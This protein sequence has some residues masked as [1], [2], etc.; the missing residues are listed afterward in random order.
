MGK[1]VIR[2]SGQVLVSNLIVADSVFTRM[3]GLLGKDSLPHGSGLWLNPCRGVHTF[4]MKFSI[5]VVFLNREHR[6]IAIINE[7]KPN[8]MTAI[9]PT[10]A[11]VLELPATSVADAHLS[12]GNIIDIFV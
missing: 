12:T 8:R 11:T 2:N 1:A 4:G 3:K 7:M 5:D 9:Y 6:V 10:V